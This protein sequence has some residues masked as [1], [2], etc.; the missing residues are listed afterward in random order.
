[1]GTGSGDP[2]ADNLPPA[3]RP[4][5]SV[6]RTFGGVGRLVVQV[7]A[8]CTSPQRHAVAE[9]DSEGGKRTHVSADCSDDLLQ[10]IVVEA[11]AAG[12]ASATVAISVSSDSAEH[13]ALAVAASAA[14][15]FEPSQY[16]DHFV[17]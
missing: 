15:E 7:T 5:S 11:F 4:T 12:L 13:S 1:M 8:D 14:G 2:A 17:G 6:V 10:P 9:I 3:W 16:L